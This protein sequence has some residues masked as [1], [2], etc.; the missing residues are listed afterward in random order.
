MWVRQQ[1]I[2]V[3][4]ANDI[5]KLSNGRLKYAYGP[6]CLLVVRGD[7]APCG[8]H[9]LN[10]KED[11]EQGNGIYDLE[12]ESQWETGTNEFHIPHIA[13]VSLLRRL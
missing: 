8:P 3:G 12:A 7:T 10:G 5:C 13:N 2:L 6:Q 4:F 11:G 9:H 1:K